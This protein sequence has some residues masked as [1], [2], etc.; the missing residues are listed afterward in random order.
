MC[1]HAL[2]REA[3]KTEKSRGKIAFSSLEEKCHV[4]NFARREAQK[5]FKHS[6]IYTIVVA[7]PWF[8][9]H[10]FLICTLVQTI[11]KNEYFLKNFK[12]LKNT[13]SPADKISGRF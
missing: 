5:C 7:L 11:L 3:N 12:I 6:A 10:S 1:T 9:I 8:E 13:S 4:I 2:K